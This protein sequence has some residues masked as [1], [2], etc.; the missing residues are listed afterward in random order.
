M[1]GTLTATIGGASMASLNTFTIRNNGEVDIRGAGTNQRELHL[2]LAAG[3]GIGVITLGGGSTNSFAE[4]PYDAAHWVTDPLGNTGTITVT[5][6][7]SSHII[8][9]FSF[10]MYIAD[11]NSHAISLVVTNGVFDVDL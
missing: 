11:S 1:A 5:S 10:T 9:T 3:T 2:H 7:S 4:Y 6:K 8:G